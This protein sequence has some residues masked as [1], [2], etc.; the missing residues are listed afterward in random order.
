MV[1]LEEA[2]H[3]QADGDDRGGRDHDV[4]TAASDVLPVRIEAHGGQ[5]GGTV[6]RMGRATARHVGRCTAAVAV[7]LLVW[8]LLALGLSAPAAGQDSE[9]A[10]TPGTVPLIPVPT[11]CTAPRPAHVV[12]TGKVIDRDYRTIRFEI[13]RVRA[14]RT[15]PF[16]SDGVID[17]RYGLDAQY[18]GNGDE[19]LVSAVVDRDL[20]ILVSRVTDPIE[21]FGGDEVIGVSETDVNCPVFES[22]M[23]TLHLDG[24]P[25]EG[26]VLTPFLDAK[27]QILAAL[28]IPAAVAVGVIFLLAMF[29]LSLAG[30]YRSVVRPSTR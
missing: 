2:P 10:P 30:L 26:G 11:G 21:N 25:I 16:A 8:V 14:G 19:Y 28:V 27:P 7:T 22:P 3:D 23:R 1:C 24:N 29:R 6:G 4:V 15:D 5:Y 20:G 9:P 13:D 18:L 17:V 12:F